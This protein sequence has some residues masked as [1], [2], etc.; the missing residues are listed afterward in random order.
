MKGETIKTIVEIFIMCLL[1]IV[2]VDY[3]KNDNR[4][5][6]GYRKVCTVV[7]EDHE[8]VNVIDSIKQTG[9]YYISPYEQEIQG[10][11]YNPNLTWT[12]E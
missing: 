10:G 2:I 1:I 9:G 7:P 5:P 3:Y 4:V 11:Y 6:E 12:K 8:I